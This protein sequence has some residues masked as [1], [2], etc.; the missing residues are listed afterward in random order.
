MNKKNMLITLLSLVSLTMAAQD[1]LI[2][3][4][5]ESIERRKDNQLLSLF[6]EE[7]ERLLKPEHAAFG[8]ECVPSFSFEWT[9]TYDSVA[10]ALIYIEAEKSIWSTT[11][12]AT[13]ELKKYKKHQKWVPRKRSK[14]YVAPGVQIDSLSISNEQVQR[15]KTLWTTAVGTAEEREV[16]ID[17]TKWE[18]FIDGQRAKTHNPNNPFVK[19]TKKMVEAVSTG[20]ESLRDSLIDNG[21]QRVITDLT[22]AP[23]PDVL[24]PGTVRRLIV[25]NG[26]PLTDLSFSYEKGF[27]GDLG[28]DELVYFNR[29]Q[30]SIRSISYLREEEQKRLYAEKYGVKIKDMVV[31]YVTVPDTHCDSYVREH[32]EL[33]LTHRYVEGYVV[34]DDGKPW[35]DA[36]VYVQGKSRM[37]DG[38]ATDSIGHFAFWVSN[39]DETLT[40]SHGL[41]FI[42]NIKITDNP[43]TIRMKRVH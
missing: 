34:D 5:S 35:A 24:E 42:G 31:E 37:G 27:V 9:L 6:D 26:Q 15:L 13:H 32:P 11:Y 23:E 12:R 30:Q 4:D 36:W 3:I 18:Y 17:G 38:T 40:A 25:V 22:V 2:R 21:Y 16:F 14:G 8:V 7:M 43:I 29:R 1:R 33:M 20:N 39:T 10:K 19:F 41:N 28:M